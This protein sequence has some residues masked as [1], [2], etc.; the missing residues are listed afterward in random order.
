MLIKLRAGKILGQY[1]KELRAFAMMLYFYSP[2]AYE[3]VRK[4]YGSNLPCRRTLQKWFESVDGAPGYTSEALSILKIKAKEAKAKN[5]TIVCNL[6]M[7]EIFIKK[8]IE[9]NVLEKK[10]YGYVDIGNPYEG[11]SEDRYEAKE[12]LTFILNAVN[13]R[14]KLPVGYFFINRL[15]S[16]EKADILKNMLI[17]LGNLN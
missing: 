6:V 16:Q 11:E 1:P 7:D 9:Y 8:H 17:F 13:E 12:A 4:I 3:Y 2:R 5:I 10:F 14:W 15:S